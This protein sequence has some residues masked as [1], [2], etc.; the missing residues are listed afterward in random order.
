[1]NKEQTKH[2]RLLAKT[3]EESRYLPVISIDPAAKSV[4]TTNRIIF[5]VV[6]WDTTKK[7]A[8]N[9]LEKLHKLFP[10]T[11]FDLRVTE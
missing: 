11:T 6:F 3:P 5:G 9:K 2:Y 7:E 10:N 8:Y 1:M 4:K